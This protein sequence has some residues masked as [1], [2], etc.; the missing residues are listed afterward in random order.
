M[1]TKQKDTTESRVFLKTKRLIIRNFKK[2]DY[3]DLFEYLADPITYI[4]EP[5][6][7]ITLKRS[8]ELCAARSKN[9]IFIAVE[10]KKEKKLIGHIYFN[11]TEPREYNIYE[12]GYIFNQEYQGHGYA[13]ESAKKIL[14]Y[15]FGKLKI[16]KVIA[17]CNP[18][19]RKSWKL[20]ER[21][22]MKREG[23]F[24]QSAYFRKNEKGEPL[25]HD[26]YAYGILNE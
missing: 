4:H 26:A 19:N 2:E 18:K 20:L 16:H 17:F 12:M 23:T 13:T 8:R 24:R 6:D 1:E 14:E 22:G 11:R 5:G 3:R 21:L 9:N 25:W 15:G 7:P 10:L